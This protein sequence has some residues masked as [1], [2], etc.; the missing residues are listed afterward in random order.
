MNQVREVDRTLLDV[1][2]KHYDAQH[3]LNLAES[4]NPVELSQ[5]GTNVFIVRIMHEAKISLMVAGTNMP[6]TGTIR[7]ALLVAV[8]MPSIFDGRWVTKSLT[9]RS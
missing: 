1:D 3:E 5:G 2:G 6:K 8:R 4:H 9:D 7:A